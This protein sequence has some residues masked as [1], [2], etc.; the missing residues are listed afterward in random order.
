EGAAELMRLAAGAA[1]P[2]DSES[3]AWVN[4]RLAG[5]EFQLGDLDGAERS[6][7]LA[8]EFQKDYPPALLLSGRMLL[9]QQRNAAAAQA[10]RRAAELNPFPEYQWALAEALRADGR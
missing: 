7:A 5:Y 8:R 1:S 3:A 2:L 6:C 9:A 4:T 10:L